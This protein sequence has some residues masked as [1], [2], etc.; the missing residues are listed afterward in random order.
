MKEGPSGC[1][2]PSGRLRDARW[3]LL[4]TSIRLTPS[5]HLRTPSPT[6]SHP[7]QAIKVLNEAQRLMAAHK[8]VITEVGMTEH[9]H[10]RLQNVEAQIFQHLGVTYLVH[11]PDRS[12]VCRWPTIRL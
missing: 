2:D 1:V 6:R 3:L 9:Q 10:H 12:Q 11:T 8:E 5:A 4:L 7:L